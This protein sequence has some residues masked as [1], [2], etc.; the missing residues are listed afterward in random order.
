MGM[1]D[2]S[3]M[4]D[5]LGLKQGFPTSA[6]SLQGVQR[7]DTVGWLPGEIEGTFEVR[8]YQPGTPATHP[9]LLPEACGKP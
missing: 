4:V 2:N 5:L 1:V 9:A 3:R 8:S 6:P 7:D